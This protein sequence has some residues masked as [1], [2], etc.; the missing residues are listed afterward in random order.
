MDR[1]SVA[2]LERILR[3]ILSGVVEDL[4]FH[5]NEVFLCLGVTDDLYDD[6]I[7]YTEGEW[8]A[9]VSSWVQDILDQTPTWFQDSLR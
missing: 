6:L 5:P 8:Y 9:S 4:F 7:F 2:D 1:Y 3:K